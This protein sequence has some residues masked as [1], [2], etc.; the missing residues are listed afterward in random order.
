ARATAVPVNKAME[1][2]GRRVLR[3]LAGTKQQGIEY[4]PETEK[5]FVEDLAKLADH[6]ENKKIHPE[7]LKHPATAYGDASFA[8]TYKKMRS[9]TG[10]VI[11]LYGFP[12][13]W[14]SQPQTVT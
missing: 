5:K 11:Y 3:Y 14:K 8:S 1:N 9:I 7:L 10:V 13:A 6:E 2:A 4:S 12:V